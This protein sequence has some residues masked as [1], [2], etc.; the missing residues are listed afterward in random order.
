MNVHAFLRL[1]ANERPGFHESGL[2]WTGLNVRRACVSENRLN[3]W[4]EIGA[5]LQRNEATVRLWEKR[6]GLPVH[7]HTHESRSSVYLDYLRS[8]RGVGRERL[9][10]KTARSPG[11]KPALSSKRKQMSRLP[12]NADC[13]NLPLCRTLGAREER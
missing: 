13:R 9:P 4:K 11:E 6:E 10:R 1:H 3:S 12:V 8:Q 5:Y 2:L 7:R